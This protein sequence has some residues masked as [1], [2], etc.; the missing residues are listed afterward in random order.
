MGNP[1]PKSS[2]A[3]RFS[4]LPQSVA[5]GAIAFA[6][7]AEPAWA[8]KPGES[9]PALKATIAGKPAALADFRGKVVYVDFWAS[10]CTPCRQSFPIYESLHKELAAQGFVLLGVNKDMKPA[11]AERF[12][13]RTPVS[14]TT[15]AD[16]DDSWAKAFAVKTMP[17]GILID[18][19]GR[20]RY[21]HSGFTS[22][23]E[24]ELRAQVAELLK[25]LA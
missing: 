10:W 11:D 23:T 25:E 21:I 9:A 17:T 7:L 18:R 4:A 8:Q 19:K 13:A 1:S 3:W 16:S 2:A 12:L 15:F 24:G 5:A 20:I 22:K 6:L 14:F